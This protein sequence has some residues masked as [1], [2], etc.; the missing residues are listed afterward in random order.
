M[1]IALSFDMNE[2]WILNVGDLKFLETPLECFLSIAYDGRG[3]G[4]ED[5][6]PWLKNIASRDYGHQ[7]ADEIAEIMALYSVSHP[8]PRS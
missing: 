8:G 6:L 4:R 1:N 7:H 3:I 5:L 2:I